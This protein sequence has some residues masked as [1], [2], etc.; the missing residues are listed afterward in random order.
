[1]GSVEQS[2][3]E[4]AQ[5][6]METDYFGTLRTI[7][8]F[9]PTM[10]EAGHGR[11][12]V[13]A[14]LIGLL[15]LPFLGHYSAAKRALEGLTES[16]NHEVRPFGIEACLLELGAFRGSSDGYA[17]KMVP[18]EA[19]GPYGSVLKNFLERTGGGFASASDPLAVAKKV[20]SLLTRRSMPAKKSVGPLPLRL[21]A[22]AKRLLPTRAFN[23]L[24]R[25]RYEA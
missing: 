8:A 15:G 24:V 19:E 17:A 6:Q 1:M 14:S 7:K 21:A 2:S 13:V 25:A 4:D 10:R 12:V 3:V 5:L 23:S 9:L 20:H 22:F 18:S 16:L 11:V